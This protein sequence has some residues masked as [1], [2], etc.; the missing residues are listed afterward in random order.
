MC[1]ESWLFGTFLR[2]PGVTLCYSR[3]MQRLTSQACSARLNS[4]L[5]IAFETFED[6]NVARESKWTDR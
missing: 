3:G 2:K 6:V 1:E 4:K 5:Q